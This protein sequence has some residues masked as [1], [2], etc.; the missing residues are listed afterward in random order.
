MPWTKEVEV[1]NSVDDLWTSRSVFG[2][3]YPS[4]ETFGREDR[5]S[6]EENYP[7]FETH[8]KS[9]LRGAEGSKKKTDSHVTD[10]SPS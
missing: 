4:F 2:R 6:T 1:A 9:P 7:E 10:R 5:Y 3:Q 8:R